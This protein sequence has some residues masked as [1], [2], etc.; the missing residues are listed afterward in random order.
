MSNTFYSFAKKCRGIIHIVSLR[1]I[2]VWSLLFYRAVSANLKKCG[3]SSTFLGKLRDL[4]IIMRDFQFDK[5]KRYFSSKHL[6]SDFIESMT[7][8]LPVSV[9]FRNVWFVHDF[10]P[11]FFFLIHYRYLLQQNWHFISNHG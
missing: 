2:N 11:A 8:R 10:F 5:K 3:K 4:K 7:K 6:F 9:Q 1:H